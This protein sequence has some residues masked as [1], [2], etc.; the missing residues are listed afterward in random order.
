MIHNP[1]F[2][3]IHEPVHTYVPYRFNHLQPDLRYTL[4]QLESKLASFFVDVSASW[5]GREQVSGAAR[6]WSNAGI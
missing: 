3:L 2:V 1:V 4:L 5:G 6:R